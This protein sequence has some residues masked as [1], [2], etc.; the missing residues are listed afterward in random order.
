M[1]GQL[2]DPAAFLTAL[3]TKAGLAESWWSEDAHIETY[4]VATWS[5][6]DALAQ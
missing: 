3:K 4:T 6:S 5:E 1:W 2:P